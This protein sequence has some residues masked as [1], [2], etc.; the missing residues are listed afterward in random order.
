MGRQVVGFSRRRA[1]VWDAD[2]GRTIATVDGLNGPAAV[3][4]DGRRSAGLHGGIKWW[5]VQTGH[6]ALFLMLPEDDLRRLVLGP[7][8]RRVAASGSNYVALWEA[9]PP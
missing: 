1:T 3:T 5:D 2:T 8:G 4:P 6:E 9:G 7:D